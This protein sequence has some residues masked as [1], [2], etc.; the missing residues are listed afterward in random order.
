[1]SDTIRLY[2]DADLHRLYTINCAGEPGVG[3]VT[4]DALGQIIAQGIC[5]VAVSRDDTPVGFLLALQPETDY[6]SKN[7]QWFDERFEDY[8]YV[9]RIAL[10]PD[11]RGSGLGTA[12]YQHGFVHFAGKA[13]LIG[14]EVNTMPP[15]PGSM[16]FHER[17]GFSQ[18]GTQTFQADYAVTYLARRLSL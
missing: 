10:H 6:G 18:V 17:L 12:L 7:Y 3:A 1:M 5:L 9:D 4:E 13:L 14:C 15:N 8:V 11:A 16:R 2:K